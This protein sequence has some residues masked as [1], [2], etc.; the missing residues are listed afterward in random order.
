MTMPLLVTGA[1]SGIGRAVALDAL[2]RAMSVVAVDRDEA[3]LEAL[4]KA[5]PKTNGQLLT[6]RLDVTDDQATQDLVAVA[7]REF[8]VPRQVFANAGVETNA[9]AHQL[10]VSDWQ[11]IININL[12]GAF[13][14]CQAAL[15]AMVANNVPGAIV[16]TSSPSAFVGF[17]GGGNAAYSAS[18]GGVSALVRSL[19]LDY[20][21]YG[22]RINAVVPGATNTRMLHGGDEGDRARFD[23]LARDQVPLGRVA[24][25]EEIAR[26]VLWLLS[27]EASYVTGSHLVID[28]GLLAKSANT[29]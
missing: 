7:T 4:R 6:A 10:R 28:G 27:D 18:K 9:S 26:A 12:T 3:G 2:R 22:I 23:A 20:A 25:P 17:A 8:G 15:Q 24:E 13:V 29:F 21:A 14:T 19:A 1:A 16:C 5:A 11:Q